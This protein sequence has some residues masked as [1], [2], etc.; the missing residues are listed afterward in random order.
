M[1]K[2][3]RNKPYQ[4][5]R[6]G[7]RREQTQTPRGTGDSQDKNV[8]SAMPIL[9]R[10]RATSPLVAKTP[11]QKRLAAAVR[12]KRIVFAIGPA[13]TGKTYY[14]ARYAAS[15]LRRMENESGSIER[16]YL[17]R[18]MVEVGEKMGFL[19]GTLEEKMWPYLKPFFKGLSDELGS[20]HVLGLMKSGRIVPAPLNFMQGESFDENCI[21]LCDEAENMT[22]VEMKM[23]LTR[24][25]RGCRMIITG[26]DDQKMIHGKSGLIDGSSLLKYCSFAEVVHLSP[27][28][29]VRS[30]EVRQILEL[31]RE[32]DAKV[33]EQTGHAERHTA[34]QSL[35]HS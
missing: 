22:P 19:P 3:K 35:I 32:R 14:A 10:P 21:V 8:G 11:S 6:R 4:Q 9:N 26:D 34:G 13:G 30:D 2:A 15:C 23:L 12:N 31:Y 28:D 16:I 5:D 18:A 25:G 27:E 20:G 7:Q 17:T 33:K 24:L 1:G 29:S